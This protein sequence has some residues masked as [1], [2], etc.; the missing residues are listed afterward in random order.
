MKRQIVL[1]A[2]LALLAL[3]ALPAYAQGPTIRVNVPFE[4]NLDDKTYPAGEYAFSALKENVIA[5]EKDGR[6]KVGLFLA[7]P[8]TGRNHGA[9]VRFQCYERSCF[10]SQ[11]WIPGLDDG[12]QARRS[13][14]E[15]EVGSRVAGRYIALAGTSARR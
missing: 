3:L 9:Q 11:V 5:L 4:F 8:V 7:N 10:L 1:S 6:M 15:V 2:T 14:T 13:R 12:F